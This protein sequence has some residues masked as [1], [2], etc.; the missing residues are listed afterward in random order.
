MAHGEKSSMIWVGLTGGIATGKSTVSKLIKNQGFSVIDADQVV[1]DLLKPG[2]SSYFEILSYFGDSI[3]DN[4]KRINNEA[5]GQI[6][7]NDK[8]KLF[9][10]EK[11]LH[12]KVQEKVRELRRVFE[13]NGEEVAFYDVPLLYEKKLQD[14][15]DHVLEIKLKLNPVTLSC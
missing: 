11:I 3:L 2:Q 13:Q 7:F 4:E 8:E 10:L 15:Y 12:P 9:K 6:V 14:S 5:L 1:H